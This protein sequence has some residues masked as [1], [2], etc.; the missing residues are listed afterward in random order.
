MGDCSTPYFSFFLIL[1]KSLESFLPIL[2]SNY[3][4][5]DKSYIFLQDLWREKTLT[6]SFMTPSSTLQ[7]LKA[8]TRLSTKRSWIKSSLLAWAFFKKTGR[9]R[10]WKRVHS[11]L[12]R[13]TPPWEHYDTSANT[14]ESSEIKD[15]KKVCS[16]REEWRTSEHTERWFSMPTLCR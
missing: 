4:Y 10:C 15:D 13:L 14:Q 3:G 12:S 1:H 11:P 6:G 9:E 5:K 7:L 8:G 16:I 2:T